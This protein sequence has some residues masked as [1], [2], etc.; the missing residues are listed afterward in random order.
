MIH[1]AVSNLDQKVDKHD[2]DTRAAIGETKDAVK[3]IHGWACRVM[4]SLVVGLL[5]VVGYLVDFVLTRA[6]KLLAWP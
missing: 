4:L 3:K 2:T 1:A 6:A 5:G